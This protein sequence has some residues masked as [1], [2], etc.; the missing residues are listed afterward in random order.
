VPVILYGDTP[1]TGLLLC[2]SIYNIV[3]IPDG[4]KS[5]LRIATL[6][7]IDKKN[8]VRLLDPSKYRI[9]LDDN[10]PMNNNFEVS[11]GKVNNLNWCPDCEST[12]KLADTNSAKFIECSEY[13]LHFNIRLL[14][15]GEDI[16]G[17]KYTFYVK[18]E[19]TLIH[20]TSKMKLAF[21]QSKLAPN[22][23]QVVVNLRKC[24]AKC[25]RAI[26]YKISPGSFK[27]IDRYPTKHCL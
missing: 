10:H 16:K 13:K 15:T 12:A 26:N 4:Q 25:R 22:T 6:S 21:D 11:L 9:I 14:E 8:Q 27:L 20:Q 1:S 24:N 23:A 17:F 2:I 5:R 7:V 3:I 18:Y 19:P